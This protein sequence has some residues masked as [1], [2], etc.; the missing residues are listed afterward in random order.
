MVGAKVTATLPSTPNQS[1]RKYVA[2]VFNPTLL[3]LKMFERKRSQA[4]PRAICQRRVSYEFGPGGGAGLGA[5]GRETFKEIGKNVVDASVN[6]CGDAEHIAVV[7]ESKSLTCAAEVA[8]KSIVA[9]MGGAE[10]PEAAGAF[11]CP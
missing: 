8:A 7:D 10:L 4:T 6:G 2:V 3:A 1:L 11:V 9:S 5:D